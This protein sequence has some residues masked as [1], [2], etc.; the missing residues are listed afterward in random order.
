LEYCMH[1]W[2]LMIPFLLRS[3]FFTNS[4]GGEDGYHQNVDKEQTNQ[5]L[6]I[7]GSDPSAHISKPAVD[8]TAR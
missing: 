2:D 4:I 8:E 7:A 5:R 3:G 6:Q 1:L